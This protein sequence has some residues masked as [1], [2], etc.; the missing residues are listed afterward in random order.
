MSVSDHAFCAACVLCG[1]AS[2]RR[3]N[4]CARSALRPFL[5]EPVTAQR[6]L[7]V[8][9]CQRRCVWTYGVVYTG[10][11]KHTQVYANT[12][13]YLQ[14][15]TG[16]CR[17]T[18]VYICRHA[19]YICRHAELPHLNEDGSVGT[20]CNNQA[21]QDVLP[22]VRASR[23]ERMKVELQ[24]AL[25]GVDDRR[26][27]EDN[28]RLIRENGQPIAPD[29]CEQAICKHMRAFR[30]CPQR[31]ATRACACRLRG[32]RQHVR[33]IMVTTRTQRGCNS[34]GVHRYASR[35]VCRRMTTAGAA[36]AL[37]QLDIPTALGAPP[38]GRW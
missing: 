35:T 9:G 6:P 26:A 5:E 3:F 17:H 18:Q 19:V 32:C 11:C 28:G 10:I 21:I 7:G 8:V 29:V 31:I 36:H 16:I 23:C 33:S 25:H 1:I 37:P 38:Q 14:T 20:V 34:T 4:A 22:R 2:Q 24:R 12:H 13:R 27:V 15:H 30:T